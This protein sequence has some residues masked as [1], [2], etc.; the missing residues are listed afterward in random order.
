MI[1]LQRSGFDDPSI[2]GA[3]LSGAATTE[4]EAGDCRTSQIMTSMAT[5]LWDAEGVDHREPPPAQIDSRRQPPSMMIEKTF[6]PDPQPQQHPK[7]VQR[8]GSADLRRGPESA[9]L[10]QTYIDTPYRLAPTLAGRNSRN[11]ASAWANVGLWRPLSTPQLAS[12]RILHSRKFRYGMAPSQSNPSLQRPLAGAGQSGS[13]VARMSRPNSAGSISMRHG[14]ARGHV[15]HDSTTAT[16]TCTSSAPAQSPAAPAHSAPPPPVISAYQASIEG[17]AGAHDLPRDDCAPARP[18]IRSQVAVSAHT[19]SATGA[20]QRPASAASPLQQ[21]QQAGGD[22]TRRPQSAVATTQQHTKASKLFT[23]GAAAA[24]PFTKKQ[25]DTVETIL[26]MMQPGACDN[27]GTPSGSQ[28]VSQHKPSIG[29]S[30]LKES[31]PDWWTVPEDVLTQAEAFDQRHAEL[32]AR[33]SRAHNAVELYAVN[34]TKAAAFRHSWVLL[35]RNRYV[36]PKPKALAI[37]QAKKGHRRPAPVAKATGWSL[38][39]SIWAPRVKWCDARAFYDTDVVERR[40]LECC[41]EHAL[42]EQDLAKIIKSADDGDDANA[43]MD[44]EADQV[45]RVLWESHEVLFCCFDYYACFGSDIVSLSFNSWS[46]FVADC[47]L[48]SNQSKYC[49]KADIDRLV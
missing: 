29:V 10:L 26:K 11:S 9:K 21:R 14:G 44:S 23:S 30:N 6:T 32:W 24:A 13:F 28:S 18:P 22:A 3:N 36:E 20:R 41:W 48:V 31:A 1:T 15:P 40:K 47:G 19:S 46:Q 4:T 35:E 33:A 38:E 39:K 37:V 16:G 12:P 7:V 43:D 5:P 27:S 2:A 45:M 49:K 25:Q 8:A 42:R 17:L 34:T